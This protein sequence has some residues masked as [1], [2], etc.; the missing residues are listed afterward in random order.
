[1]YWFYTDVFFLYIFI[2]SMHIMYINDIHNEAM[3]RIV[4]IYRKQLFIVAFKFKTI[5]N[6]TN[7]FKGRRD[8]G[9]TSNTMDRQIFF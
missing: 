7:L 5:I 9:L 1:M 3:L 8:D 6:Y 2:H 4:G